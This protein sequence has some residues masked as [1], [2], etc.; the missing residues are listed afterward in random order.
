MTTAASGPDVLTHVRR[1]VRG[2][3]EGSPVY[4]ES[5]PAKRR[6]LAEKMV[7]VSMMAARLLAEDRRLT[8]DVARRSRGGGTRRAPAA[9]AT[10][11]SAGD[12][13]GMQAVKATAGTIT[14]VRDSIDFPTYVQSLITGVF[15]AILSSTT[16]QVGALGELLDNVSATSDE[17]DSTISDQEVARW[18]VGKF[19]SILTV[20]DDGAVALRPGVDLTGEGGRLKA[21]LSASDGEI[22]G[23]DE[24][25]IEGTLMPLVRRKMGRDK[26]SVLASMVQMGLQ[27]IVVDEGRIH[28]SMDM[29]VDATSG[30]QEDKAQRDDFRFNAG[31]AG[32]F[33]YGPWSAS[34]SA[35]TSIGQVKSDQQ[36]TNEQIGVRAGLRSSVDLAFRTE[37]VPLDR[38]ADAKAR[39]KI[40]NNARVPI[41]VGGGASILPTAPAP[42]TFA[43]LPLD[44]IPAPPTVTAAAPPNA[45]G[46]GTR[47]DG[48]KPGEKPGDDKAQP[49]DKAKPADK[50]PPADNKAAPADN[51]AKA[52]DKSKAVVAAPG[53]TATTNP[54]TTTGANPPGGANPTTATPSSA[55]ATTSTT[56]APNA[57]APANAAPG[58]AA[59]PPGQTATPST[60]TSGPGLTGSLT[61]NIGFHT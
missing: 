41:D 46:P 17:F 27:R 28:A 3:L 11:Q 36:Y 7:G 42:A 49:A 21:G 31:A 19:P 9:L 2:M 57:A 61:G 15:Q 23:I 40:D 54:A 53:G 59:T 18:A 50:A 32:S 60:T 8:E 25:D 35:S 58:A 44:N 6:E 5:D 20:G 45:G 37:Q 52:P 55:P 16:Q 22:S 51:K 47:T 1:T 14:A 56:A 4:A 39:V 26:Q 13:L 33:G 38:M 48:K 12:Q 30:S 10:A 24:S 34:A 43:P 29:R